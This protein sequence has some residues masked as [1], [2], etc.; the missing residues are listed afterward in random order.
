MPFKRDRCPEV[1]ASIAPFRDLEYVRLAFRARDLVTLAGDGNL[2]PAP[3]GRR[4]A[5][6]YAA[7]VAGGIADHDLRL[8]A[9]GCS[10]HFR[11]LIADWQMI[12][13]MP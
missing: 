8:S 11:S 5:G 13:A 1:E 9:Y 3:C 6:D 10:C 7:T 4:A 2:S 12:P